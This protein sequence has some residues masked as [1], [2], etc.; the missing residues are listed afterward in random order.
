MQKSCSI[1]NLLP[2]L[3]FFNLLL[4]PNHYILVLVFQALDQLLQ[5]DL[6]IRI[7]AVHFKGQVSPASEIQFLNP[8]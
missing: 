6:V 8:F 3:L 5:C 7:Q 4:V 2:F 1:V